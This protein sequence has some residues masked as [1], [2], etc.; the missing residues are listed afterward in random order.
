[1]SAT[2]TT[3]LFAALDTAT[4]A[5]IGNGMPLAPVLAPPHFPFVAISTGAAN[6]EKITSPS[7]AFPFHHRIIVEV[8]SPDD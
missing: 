3:S 1:M 7:L 6:R 8:K 4:G 5:V 2:G